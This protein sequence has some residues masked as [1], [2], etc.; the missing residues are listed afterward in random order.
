MVL[1]IRKL[2]SRGK[3]T[4][5]FSFEFAPDKGCML[6]PLCGFKDNVKVSGEYEIFDD[7]SVEVNFKLS[8]VLAGQCSYC[9]EET[10]REIV[11]SA[12]ALFVKDSD[13]R[14]NYVYDGNRLDLTP[15]V[16]DALLFSQPKVL[17]CREDCKGIKLTDT[18]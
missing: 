4:G 2:L 16:T 14:D 3:F 7:D 13:D 10:E 8:Y 12:E 5:D 11:Y 6:I 1:V 15:A 9:L 18:K 17:L